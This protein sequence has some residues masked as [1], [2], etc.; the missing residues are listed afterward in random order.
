M[1]LNWHIIYRLEDPYFIWQVSLATSCRL[2]YCI[3][4]TL[5]A[6]RPHVQQSGGEDWHVAVVRLGTVHRDL[7]CK[8][9]VLCTSVRPVNVVLAARVI[10]IMACCHSSCTGQVVLFR[11]CCSHSKLWQTLA[12]SDCYVTPCKTILLEKL[13]VAQAFNNFPVM[14][15]TQSLLACPLEPD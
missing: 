12:P 15:G 14:Y 3:N 9:F 5:A 13:V 2:V 8:V 1:R 6:D 10:M 4:V 7:F 11:I